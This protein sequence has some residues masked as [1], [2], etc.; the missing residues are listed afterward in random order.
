MPSGRLAPLLA[1]LASLVAWTSH[2][3]EPPWIGHEATRSR[4]TILGIDGSAKRVILDSPRRLA[5]PDSMPDGKALV[6]NGGGGLWRVATEGG[7]AEP[8]AIG[9]GSWID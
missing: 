1:A 4:L 9:A 7:V 3:G 5:A 8:L 6:V 2:A